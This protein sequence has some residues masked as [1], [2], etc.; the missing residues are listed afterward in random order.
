M[1]FRR[2]KAKVGSRL[3]AFTTAGGG[4]GRIGKMPVVKDRA[5]V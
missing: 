3:R 5:R 4:R 2:F 1:T